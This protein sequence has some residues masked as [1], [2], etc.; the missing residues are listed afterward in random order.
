MTPNIKKSCRIC[1]GKRSLVNIVGNKELTKILKVSANIQVCF[2]SE[3]KKKEKR[4]DLLCFLQI[5]PNDKL[6]KQICKTCKHGLEVAYKLRNLGQANEKKFRNEIEQMEDSDDEEDQPR[7]KKAASKNQEA[8]DDEVNVEEV[9][10][11]T[12]IEPAPKI[13]IE[14]SS[15]GYENTQVSYLF[16][17][18]QAEL[19]S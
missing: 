13:K 12:E 2:I 11:I 14:A 4:I 17:I 19:Y 1:A 8:S 5:K 10:E 16:I 15:S 3:A 18:F 6:P 7:K 9:E